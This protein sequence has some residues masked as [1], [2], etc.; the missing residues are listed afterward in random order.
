MIV[1]SLLVLF[2]GQQ[3]AYALSSGEWPTFLVGPARTSFNKD[4]TIIN[5]TTAPHL[6][7]HWTHTVTTRISAEPVEVQA[8]GMV[9]WGSWDGVEHGSHQSDGTDVW[10]ANLGTMTGSCVHLPHGVVSTA[11]IASVTIGGV[12]TLVDFVGGGDNNFYAL[13]A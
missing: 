4:E 10:T 11:T 9:Y 7:V 13:N 1:V 6:K 8:T 2:P 3:V 12:K 5:P